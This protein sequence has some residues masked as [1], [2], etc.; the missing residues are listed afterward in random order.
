MSDNAIIEAFF[1]LL[2]RR[3]LQK[4]D[5]VLTADAR[6]DFPKTRPLIGKNAIVQF[7]KLLFRQYPQLDFIVAGIIRQGP[8][9]AVHWTNRGINRNGE[10]YANEGVT[11]IDLDGNRIRRISDFFK[12]TE[13]F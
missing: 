8:R 7:L 2:N 4:M 9:A 12:N 1:E 5:A 11:L 13:K 3:D 10:T 6:L